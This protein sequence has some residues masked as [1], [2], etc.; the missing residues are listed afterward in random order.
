MS[1]HGTIATTGLK[2]AGENGVRLDITLGIR[3]GADDAALMSDALAQHGAQPVVASDPALQLV[4]PTLRWP[5]FGDHGNATATPVVQYYDPAGDTVS[6]G[7]ALPALLASEQ[8][9]SAARAATYAVQ[10]PGTN[11]RGVTFDGVNTVSWS[12]SRPYA[13]SAIEV[14]NI[15]VERSTGFILGSE[16]AI[17]PNLQYFANPGNMMP[18][19]FDTRYLHTHENGHVAGLGHSSDP[20]AVMFPFFGYGMVGR[21]L[22]QASIDAIP[23]LSPLHPPQQRPFSATLTGNT[24]LQSAFLASES[25]AGNGAHVGA[26]QVHGSAHFFSPLSSGCGFAS[27]NVTITTA[28]G[29]QLSM[30][31]YDVPCNTAAAPALD[32]EE[33]TYAIAGGTEFFVGA[34][35]LGGVATHRGFTQALTTARSSSHS[36]ER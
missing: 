18:T 13:P 29:D 11:T 21:G 15:Y 36:W 35:G 4:L 26:D 19:S 10:Y 28:N 31:F 30:A 2:Q 32:D 24:Q 7:G 5:Q 20:S 34:S 17:N 16:V 14:T 22:T 33:G 3:P 27:E 23:M 12:T 9:W 8:S 25:G 6:H 1:A